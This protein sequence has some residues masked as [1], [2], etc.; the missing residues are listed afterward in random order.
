M[1]AALFLL[2]AA[3]PA[4]PADAGLWPL[5]ILAVGVAIVLGTILVLRLNAF[6]G[7][8]AAALAVS[9]LAPGAVGDKATRIAVEFGATAGKIG[10]VIAMAAIIG[11]AMTA[12]GA[13]DR[14]VRSALRTLGERRAAAALGASGFV[15]SIPVFFDTVFYLLYPLA[16]STY[17]RTGRHYVKYLIAL[18]AGGTATHSLVPPTPGPLYVAAD[19]GVDLG[20]MIVLGA[21]IAIPATIAGVLYA[22]WIDGRLTLANPP[23]DRDDDALPEPP[24]DDR[25]PGLAA[26]LLPIV[27]PVVLIAGQAIVGQLAAPTEPPP[28]AIADPA[29]AAPAETPDETP[30]RPWAAAIAPYAALVG[31]PNVALMASAAAALALYIVHRRPPRAAVTAMIEESLASAGVIILI[32]SAGGAFGAMLREAQ[33]GQAIR[34][35]M[36]ADDSA[37]GYGMLLLAFTMAS[38]LK[39]AQGSSTV[40]MMTTSG[41][42]AAMLHAGATLGYHPV[43]LAAAIGSGA[44][45]VSWMNDSGFWVVCKMSGLTE[46]ECLKTWTVVTGIV[47]VTGFVGTLTLAWLLPLA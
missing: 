26:S 34:T 44:I 13:A 39:I 5:A 18:G 16:R 7:L 27:L 33:V 21:A 42:I 4:A 29:V 12:S 28:S 14:I 19:I 41:M 23:V 10:I 40:A 20:L 3:A 37:A 15:L 22:G 45:S 24:P 46:R 47:G 35:V 32:T 38:L 43:Y 8:V 25:L 9:L 11:A 31:N 36:G 2:A 1:G 30:Q 17:R 6:I